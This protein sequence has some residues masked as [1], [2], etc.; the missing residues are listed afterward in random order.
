MSGYFCPFN[1]GIPHLARHRYFFAH[2]FY[3]RK[4]KLAN[5]IHVEQFSIHPSIF[6]RLGSKA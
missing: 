4:M 6:E 3:P 1:V 5:P 2:Y